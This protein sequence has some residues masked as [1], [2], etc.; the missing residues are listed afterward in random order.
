MKNIKINLKKL[1][2]TLIIIIIIL[3]Y[4]NSRITKINAIKT[5]SKNILSTT[6]QLSLD[7]LN[8]LYNDEITDEFIEKNIYDSFSKESLAMYKNIN[9]TLK[10][11]KLNAKISLEK[12]NEIR[13]YKVDKKKCYYYSGN[14]KLTI[15]NEDGTIVSSD[16]KKLESYIVEESKEE[17]IFKVLELKL[18]NIE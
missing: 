4:Y 11:S 10:E 9:K 6:Q 13:N 3:F 5:N 1:I 8:T 12:T 18:K 2:P 14:I 16:N 17:K 7:I 15:Y